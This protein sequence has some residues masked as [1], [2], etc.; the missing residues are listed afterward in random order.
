M[1]N[2]E[3]R[4]KELCSTLFEG[5]DCTWEE[6]SIENDFLKLMLQLAEEVHLSTCI[7]Q[8]NLDL[9]AIEILYSGDSR[10]EMIY[11]EVIES[12]NLLQYTLP[13]I[14][15]LYSKSQI[16]ELLQKQRE[17]CAKVSVCGFDIHS[18]VDNK[19]HFEPV[20]K[21]TIYDDDYKYHNFDS[22]PSISVDEESILNAKLKI[23]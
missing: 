14:N 8:K 4:A 3:T 20:Y 18:I 19:D 2:Y 23:D 17:L 13:T 15:S 1:S 21:K 9:K 11:E 5:E 7:N 22:M 10:K 12:I 16:E 6:D